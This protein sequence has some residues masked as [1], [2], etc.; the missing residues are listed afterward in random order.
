MQLSER[1]TQS[2]QASL[3]RIA[4]TLTRWFEPIVRFM[5]HR[6]TNGMTEGFNN[7]I[8]LIQRMASGLRNAHKRRKRILAWCGAP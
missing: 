3:A 5:R 8:K 6:H 1:A 2:A 7:K 4:G